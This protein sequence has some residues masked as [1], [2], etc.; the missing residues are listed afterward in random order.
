VIVFNNT[1]AAFNPAAG[2]GVMR[3][4]TGIRFDRLT[5][6]FSS[7]AN[8]A[9]LGGLVGIPVFIAWHSLLQD[10][11]GESF[12]LLP[13]WMAAGAML[14]AIGNIWWRF[15]GMTLTEA[16]LAAAAN[17]RYMI[18]VGLFW[19]G[20]GILVILGVS[21][22]LTSPAAVRL[23]KSVAIPFPE[24]NSLVTLAA[25]V[26]GAYLLLLCG[27]GTIVNAL[28]QPSLGIQN[29]HGD[30]RLVRRTLITDENVEKT[31]MRFDRL[32]LAADASFRFEPS[33]RSMVWFQV[34]EG[35][36]KLRTVLYT[37]RLS[38][39][40]S[41]FLPP[42]FDATLSTERGVSLLRAELPDAGR[43]DP[44]FST[45]HPLFTASDWTREL[46]LQ[47]KN[48]GRKRVPLVTA[49][50]CWTTAIKVQMV[51]Y[52][53]GTK[54]PSYRHEGAESFIYLL[55]GR[56]TAGTHDQSSSVRKGDLVWFRD[57]EWHRLEAAADSEMRFLILHAPGVFR[58]AWDDPSKA[59]AW[60]P[61]G[62]DINGRETERDA[63]ERIANL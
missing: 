9:A 56:G 30:A 27:L 13:N 2:P 52:P 38:D 57:G 17:R 31:G 51:I 22:F 60:S 63:R 14:G 20:A 53:P 29:P 55:S 39:R 34:L 23:A 50:T 4:E 48:D 41:V 46:V 24:F 37:H 42:A 18:V 12:S 7:A 45:K 28:N 35:D 8:G 43:F 54:S 58:T 1:A 61:T 40:H 19:V 16:Q 33:A 47:C 26:G 62:L 36:A 25:Y 49:E 3:R 44:E 5:L 21:A 32:T 11:H 10:I 59:S 15:S 6:V